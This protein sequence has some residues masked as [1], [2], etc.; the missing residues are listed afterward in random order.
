MHFTDRPLLNTYLLDD[1]VRRGLRPAV[2]WVQIE[3]RG[4]RGTVHDSQHKVPVDS[5]RPRSHTSADNASE[6]SLQLGPQFV[7]LE[8]N[9][10]ATRVESTR[11]AVGR[12]DTQTIEPVHLGD[13]IEIDHREDDAGLIVPA[14][15]ASTQHPTRQLKKM[16]TVARSLL[17]LRQHRQIDGFV[18][19]G[20]DLDAL[21]EQ[22]VTGDHFKLRRVDRQL[23]AGVLQVLATDLTVDSG[24]RTSRR[25]PHG[26]LDDRAD[27]HVARTELCEQRL[28]AV[29]DQE[30]VESPPVVAGHRGQIA[31]LRNLRV[32]LHN[33]VDELLLTR[34]ATSEAQ[35]LERAKARDASELQERA[36]GRAVGEGKAA[37][38]LREL[39][40]ALDTT[41][42]AGG[43]IATYVRHRKTL[44]L[45]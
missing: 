9:M 16:S 42:G 38:G 8:S 2:V 21:G 43:E 33:P 28:E 24:R 4:R 30:G 41:V 37:S 23:E 26:L 39:G 7:H 22:I 31:K 36:G 3:H 15:G 13:L 32:V 44:S 12:V 10:L 20:G 14:V 6:G 17:V 35:A 40:L 34:V 5:E 27:A 19:L 29:F 18:P 25:P 1:S 45:R 11:I